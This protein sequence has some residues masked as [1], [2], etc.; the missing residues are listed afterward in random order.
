MKEDGLE[1]LLNSYEI[2]RLC[3]SVFK[4]RVYKIRGFLFRDRYSFEI[5]EYL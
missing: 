1:V 5:L 4:D 3:I 2:F